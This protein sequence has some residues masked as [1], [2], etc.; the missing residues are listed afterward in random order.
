MSIQIED[1]SI[2]FKLF[3]QIS[4]RFWVSF[5]VLGVML[6]ASI[7]NINLLLLFQLIVRFHYVSE[8]SRSI[9]FMIVLNVIIAIYSGYSLLKN[10]T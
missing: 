5:F 3:T 10:K 2:K 9:I 4:K 1:V 7:I 6:N 8:V